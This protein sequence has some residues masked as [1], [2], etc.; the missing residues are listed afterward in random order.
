[1]TIT[2]TQQLAD[3]GFHA[4]ELAVQR[5][6]GVEQ[7]AARLSRMLEPVALTGGISRFLSDRTFLVISGRDAAGQLWTSPLVGQ[8]GFLEVQSDTT[9]AIHAVIPAGDPLHGLPAGQKVG[10]TTVE[11]ATRRRV[12]INGM[13]IL[14][15]G[16]L[17]L[18]EVE[19]AY[20]NCPKYIHQRLLATANFNRA[21]RD[22][23]RHGTTLGPEDRELIRGADTFFLG[24]ANPDR[25]ADASHRGGPPGVVRVD[26]HGLWWPDYPGNNLFNS[27]GNLALNPEA[28][29]LF[30]DF[31][32]G[33]T[34]HLSGTTEIEWGEPDRPGDDG[35]T[36]RIARF[37]LQR[38]VAGH[39]FPARETAHKPYPS[40]PALT[41]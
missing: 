17:F 30:F 13:L 22:H 21:N 27:F 39:L 2:G 15:S 6:A 24:T 35:H 34:L 20:G 37:T 41:D 9:V 40:N 32:T 36:G 38:L 1:M 14:S 16:N 29:L 5:K 31:A 19:Q 26:E 4:G 8:R 10:M 18:I 3:V 7:D 28:A 25:G 11:F 12:R 23:I 33:R